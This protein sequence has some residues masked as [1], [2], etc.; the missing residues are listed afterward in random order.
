MWQC[1]VLVFLSCSLPAWGQ[2]GAT[3][4][5]PPSNL[6]RRRP[7][8]DQ[9]QGIVSGKPIIIWHESESREVPYNRFLYY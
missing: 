9:T 4:G 8:T 3:K 1:G 6:F 2:H 5:Q 7:I